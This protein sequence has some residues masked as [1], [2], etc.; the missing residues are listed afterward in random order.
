[1]STGLSPHGGSPDAPGSQRSEYKE[2][3][4]SRITQ[5]TYLPKEVNTILLNINKLTHG[6]STTVWI[7][8]VLSI[9]RPFALEGIIDSSLPRP[10][11]SE[12]NFERWRFWAPVVAS[13]LLTQIEEQFQTVMKAQSIFKH[14]PIQLTIADQVFDVIKSL[15]TSNH[16]SYVARELGKWHDM[17]RNQYRSAADFVMAYQ[18]Q[19]NRLK[20]EGEEEPC[21]MALGRLLH[22]LQGEFMRV[23]FIRSEVEAMDRE[24]D[25]RLFCY[26]C[27]LLIN[28]T[29]EL[30]D[31]D[32]GG[33]SGSSSSWGGGEVSY[34]A[35][36]R[37]QGPKQ[38]R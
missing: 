13:W 35:W 28:E 21:G 3:T 4:M 19:Y 16:R 14:D 31:I 27:K 38:P 15:N 24:V 8:E 6:S 26:Y 32:N 7:N 34:R 25:Y 33:G 1:M 18:N 10:L 9:L 22:E 17:R 2:Q 12:L 30:R 37:E 29:R 11:P 5:A 23:N 36:R 20:V